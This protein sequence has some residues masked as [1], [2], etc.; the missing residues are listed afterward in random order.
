[1][2]DSRSREVSSHSGTV[3]SFL[4]LPKKWT[5]QLPFCETLTSSTLNATSSLM[6]A[7]ELYSMATIS[8]VSDPG[9]QH[10]AI[11]PTSSGVRKS[12]SL[13]RALRLG[14]LDISASWPICWGA[15][16]IAYPAND[17]NAASL[18]LTVLAEQPR[19]S[20]R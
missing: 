6:R 19:P 13:R 7:P 16:L 4:P 17:Q 9:S 10:S 3:L 14:I 12:I 18:Q 1:M 11:H 15:F 20:A 5:W 8:S 2:C